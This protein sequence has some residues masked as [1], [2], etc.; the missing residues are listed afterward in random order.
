MSSATVM[1]VLARLLGAGR[2]ATDRMCAGLR[3][4]ADRRSDA[5]SHGR[6]RMSWDV[7]VVGGGLAGR[8]RRQPPRPGRPAGGPVR[9]RA[10]A[11]RQGLRRIP[12]RG[13]AATEL[14]ELGRLLDRIGCRA[15]RAGARR[16]R[17]GS[18]AAATVAVPRLG[19]LAARAGRPAAATAARHGVEVRRGT[20]GARH[21]RSTVAACGCS[22]SDGFATAAAAILASGKHD[23]RGWRRRPAASKLI[24]L[25]LHLR[26]DETQR[27]RWR[28][29]SSWRLF[30]GGYA[31]LQLVEN[32]HRQFVPRRV[33]ATVTRNSVATG[34]RLRRDGTTPRAAPRRC[35]RPAR[36]HRWR[37][38][39]CPTATSTDATT[40]ASVYR[41]GDQAAVIPSFAG[42]GMAMALHS[43]AT[44]R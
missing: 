28:A 27:R 44:C 33:A 17:A 13:G 20:S 18:T 15:D 14:A 6:Q 12:E 10:W 24:G 30:D 11:A 41:V 32:R 3:P 1:F 40:T 7:A 42:D 22:A 31:G 5:L 2:V 37:S 16:L 19:S 38:P 29:M 25:K 23:L 39:G 26:L 4:R 43:G 35:P 9:A 21:S 36:R 34:A 8:S